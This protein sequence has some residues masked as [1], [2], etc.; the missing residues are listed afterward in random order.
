MDHAIHNQGV[1]RVLTPVRDIRPYKVVLEWFMLYN[2]LCFVISVHAP[3][4]PAAI[5]DPD[6]YQL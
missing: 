3:V 4:F 1:S 2:I 6:Q 5:R